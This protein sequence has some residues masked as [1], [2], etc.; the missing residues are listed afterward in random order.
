[1]TISAPGLTLAAF[2]LLAAPARCEQVMET[3]PLFGALVEI[4]VESED[5]ETGQNRIRD[6]MTVARRL[7]ALLSVEDTTSPLTRL[8]SNAGRAAIPVPLDL[9]R[10]LALS[11][12]MTRSTGGA[13]DVTVGPLLRR[14]QA[15]GADRSSASEALALVGGDKIVLEPPENAR[16]ANE[17]MSVDFGGIVRGY[18]LERMAAMLRQ[19]GVEKALLE[20]ADTTVLAVGPPQGEAPF[21]VWV[22]RGKVTL[23]SVALRDRSLSTARAQRRGEDGDSPPIVDPRSGRF[24]DS[25]RQ[26]TVIARDAAIA[27]AWST[28]LVVDPDGAL[29]LLEE[30]RDVEAL[31]FD[32]H[33]EHRSPRF[34]DFTGWKSGRTRSDEGARKQPPPAPAENK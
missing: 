22:A 13:F 31:V 32:E 7:E 16:L 18:A 28:A 24:V 6:A 12:L 14:R 23:G 26:A 30:P 2:L 15:A 4:T 33:G 11:R 21:R 29:G 8:H 10:L 20:F 17:G 19:S 25:D 3:H 1:M 9:Y 34:E 5:R 27:E